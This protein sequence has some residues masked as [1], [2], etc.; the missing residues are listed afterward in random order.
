MMVSHCSRRSAI[1]CISWF[2]RGGTPLLFLCALATAAAAPPNILWIIAE[3]MGVN[4]SCYGETALQ[5]PVVDRMAREGVRF[6]NAFATAP[7]CSA[8]RSALITGMYQTTLGAHNHQSSRGSHK[9]FLPQNVRLVPELFKAAGYYVTNQEKADYNFEWDPSVYAGEDWSGR[10]PG[11]PFF[12][13]VQLRGGKLRDD[14]ADLARIRKE[15]P[16]LVGPQD[17]RIPPYYPDHPEI[18]QD[19]A[20]YLN[21][22]AY[23]DREVGVVLERLRKDG[24][25]ANTYVFFI[26]D[27]GISHARGKQFLYDEGI[28]VPLVLWG[29]GLPAG[30]V[31]EDL[32]E[33]IDLGPTSLALAGIPIPAVMQ[34][35]DLLAGLPPLEVSFA[36]RDRCDE[37]VDRIRSVRTSQYK[38]I[39]NYYPERP[40]LQPS[41][42]KDGKPFIQL[43]RRLDRE[44]RLDPVQSLITAP[45]RPPEELYDLRND[46]W[47][48]HNLAGDAGSR[49]V[50]EQ[51]RTRLDRWIVDTRDQGE[52]PESEAAYDSEMEVYLADKPSEE[53]R[54]QI[55]RNIA[56]MK[57]WQAAG[58]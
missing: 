25:A 51:L 43:I 19:W 31:R 11:Q 10:A 38:Y 6:A 22:V 42:Y 27:H 8:A 37:T 39:R 57:A 46:P 56:Q 5:T 29:P 13:Q 2:R 40:Y 4:F 41:S 52:I 47:E 17:V 16:R 12:A 1:D 58:R 3:D 14:K 21:A 35:R 55:R 18:R 26:T 7:V 54:A 36:A 9:I 15:L 34:G 48:I 45:R 53:R 23:T 28:H 50:L 33:L 49:P 24:D 44:G 32:A 30:T 20:D